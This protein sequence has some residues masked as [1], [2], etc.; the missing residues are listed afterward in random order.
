M[1]SLESTQ[2]FLVRR[3][4][5]SDRLERGAQVRD[6]GVQAAERARVDLP[7]A[8]PAA[9]ATVVK[10]IARSAATRCASA[11]S[12]RAGRSSV[13]IPPRPR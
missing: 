6:L 11:V 2:T 5:R 9:S 7:G 12:T 13:V 8:M 3:R 1:R 4:P 10:V